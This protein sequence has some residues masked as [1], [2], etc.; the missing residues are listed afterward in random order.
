MSDEQKNALLSLGV[1]LCGLML[2]FAIIANKC[3]DINWECELLFKLFVFCWCLIKPQSKA[4]LWIMLITLTTDLFVYGA[5]AYD[6]LFRSFEFL[7]IY[8]VRKFIFNAILVRSADSNYTGV[9]G[10]QIMSVLISFV[11][12]FTVC[13]LYNAFVTHEFDMVN[14]AL[15]GALNIIYFILHMVII[16]KPLTDYYHSLYQLILEE[17]ENPQ[18]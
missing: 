10:Y 4:P 11:P 6:T 3:I 18:F 15:Y 14:F 16:N 12:I 7:T 5:V 8:L 9:L 17:Y 2:M 13:L 1:T